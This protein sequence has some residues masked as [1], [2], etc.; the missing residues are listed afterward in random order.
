MVRNLN[1]VKRNAAKPFWVLALGIGAGVVGGSTYASH[2]V[3]EQPPHI[4][5]AMQDVN[6]TIGQLRTDGDSMSDGTWQELNAHANEQL[7]FTEADLEHRG[8]IMDD[9]KVAQ[10]AGALVAGLSAIRLATIVIPEQ[11]EKRSINPIGW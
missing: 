2:L 6:G 9:L 10:T 5:A 1:T 4:A 7:M 3:S 11:R 8:D